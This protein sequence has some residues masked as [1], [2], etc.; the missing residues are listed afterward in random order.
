[1]HQLG[2]L[3]GGHAV[4]LLPVGCGEVGCLLTQSVGGLLLLS[5]HLRND[6]HIWKHLRRRLAGL[7][8]GVLSLQAD[9][10]PSLVSL[11]EAILVASELGDL[12]GVPEL[13]K[14]PAP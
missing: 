8:P 1:M 6:D 5:Q 7:L 3:L 4:H 2:S 14:C 10:G 13:D 12:G 9:F 11:V